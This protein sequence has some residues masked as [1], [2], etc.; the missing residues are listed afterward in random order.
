MPAGASRPTGMKKLPAEEI[1]EGDIFREILAQLVQLQS[2]AA[3]LACSIVLVQQTLDNSLVNGLNSCLV[4]GLS[5]SL[6]AGNQGSVELL[7]NGLQSS[8]VS[9]VLLVSNLGRDNILLRGLDV[10]HG[11]TS[12]FIFCSCTIQL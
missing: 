5:S 12:Y 6:V 11:H 1:R 2:H 3:L 9:L 4:S 10:C 8:L 7:Q